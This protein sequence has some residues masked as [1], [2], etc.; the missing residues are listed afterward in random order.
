MV[1]HSAHPKTRAVSPKIVRP[2]NGRWWT[3]V[4]GQ[5]LDARTPQ[6]VLDSPDLCFAASENSIHPRIRPHNNIGHHSTVTVQLTQTLV[7]LHKFAARYSRLETDAACARS[8]NA[9]RL[10]EC[11]VAPSA[12]LPRAHGLSIETRDGSATDNSSP[13]IAVEYSEHN[14]S[15]APRDTAI[16]KSSIRSPH[17]HAQERPSSARNKSLWIVVMCCHSVEVRRVPD[18]C[19][20]RLATSSGQIISSSQQIA[21]S[22]DHHRWPRLD[23]SALDIACTTF[24]TTDSLSPPRFSHFEADKPGSPL[25]MPRPELSCWFRWGACFDDRHFL[26][27]R[28]SSFPSSR[29][30]ILCSV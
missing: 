9:P 10:R 18:L 6:R 1:R 22:H 13:K 27:G 28:A 29:L 21:L 20:K 14:W 2:A 24:H 12:S 15:A 4:H 5:S 25:G 11:S 30:F 23:E 17:A 16:Q 7:R 8:R 3:T 19:G 26:P